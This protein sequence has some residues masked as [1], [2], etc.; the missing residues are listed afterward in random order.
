MAPKRQLKELQQPAVAPSKRV[1]LSDDQL[2]LMDKAEFIATIS[3][4]EDELKQVKATCA[5]AE[6]ST[7]MTTQE[8][9][10]KADKARKLMIK[11][12]KSQMKVS[13]HWEPS[14]KHGGARFS[15]AGS[16]PNT[17]VFNVLTGHAV[18]AKKAKKM[19][20]FTPAEFEETVAGEDVSAIVRYN[21]L[22]PVGKSVNLRWKK[23]NGE[24]TVNGSYKLSGGRMG[25]KD[26]DHDRES[27]GGFPDRIWRQMEDGH[28][29][30]MR[31]LE[32]VTESPPGGKR[33]SSN[34]FVDFKEFIDSNLSSLAESFKSL[35]SNINELKTKMLEEREAWKQEELAVWQRWTHNADMTPDH[36]AMQRERM[37][38]KDRTDAISSTLLLLRE[39]RER[40]KHVP[41]DKI[42][43]LYQDQ[44]PMLHPN[45]TGAPMLSYGGACYYQQDDGYNA[46]STRIF[47]FGT[48]HYRWLSIDWLKR[49]PYS[50]IALEAH[51]DL[52]NYGIKWRAAF[53]DLL[54]AAVDKPMESKEQVGYRWPY[55][56]A[57]STHHGAGID[58]MLS[59]ICRG[60]LPLQFPVE[61]DRVSIPHNSLPLN[62]AISAGT[63]S[64]MRSD[65]WSHGWHYGPTI[66]FDSLLDEI[67]TPSASATAQ[68]MEAI[69]PETEQDL[70]KHFLDP[71]STKAAMDSYNGETNDTGAKEDA[72][73][74][75][76]KQRREDAKD[77]LYEA[78]ESGNVRMLQN[79]LRSEQCK[80]DI[81]ELVEEIC[82]QEYLGYMPKHWCELW[83]KATGE[84]PSIDT[85]AQDE[86]QMDKQ[87]SRDIADYEQRL[88]QEKEA[89]G[90]LPQADVKAEM[91]SDQKKRVDVLSSLTTTHTTRMPDGTI[92]TKIVLKQRFADGR[93][94][95]EEKV[96]TY[97]EAQ[98]VQPS[99][100]KPKKGGWFWI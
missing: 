21:T 63:I 84:K 10:E 62:Q 72:E 42:K 13:P 89:L 83:V 71:D 81:D 11:C 25:G 1:R 88:K 23:E 37:S 60:I 2:Q 12:I 34:F 14:C 73:E 92:T 9:Q 44:G 87:V 41:K 29:Q 99:E 47:R 61:F 39:N 50:P 85:G 31:D 43:A 55:Q 45:V 75:F 74:W 95:V 7:A 59:L 15:Y 70:Y 48:P 18:D 98:Q 69:Q 30:F 20:S 17:A 57:A 96:H 58:W 94:E 76:V 32:N 35:P 65:F 5:P 26:D 40:N 53:E 22:Y 54:S 46:P 80:H 6:Q 86:I 16:L 8:A 67:T 28:R 68:I 79:L 91:E 66:S 33:P 3:A 51:K 100:E 56:N 52:S 93:E 90:L 49:S 19:C 64:N 82:D 77:D 36:A 24:F 38:K 97:Q 27:S 4:L 78:F